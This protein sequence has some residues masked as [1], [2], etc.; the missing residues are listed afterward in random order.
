MRKS[1]SADDGLARAFAA[2]G[3]R[4]KLAKALKIGLPAVMK[5]RRVPP[6]RVIEIE[7]LFGIDREIL[8][9]DLHPQRK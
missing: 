8:R 3:S 5:W 9:P 4:Y 6:H 1:K 7:R 2:A